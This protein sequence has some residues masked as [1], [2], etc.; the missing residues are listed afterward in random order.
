MSKG[1]MVNKEEFQK[2]IVKAVDMLEELVMVNN[3][4]VEV[5]FVAAVSFL[6][7]VIPQI[8][9]HKIDAEAMLER[10]KG[11]AKKDR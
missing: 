3:I 6:S 5:I 4:S 10:L 2:E 8:K 11:Y 1:R 7:H 9:G